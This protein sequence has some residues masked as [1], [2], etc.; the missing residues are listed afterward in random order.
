MATSIYSSAFWKS[1]TE[2]AIKTVGQSALAIVPAVF[3]ADSTG[4]IDFAGVPWAGIAGTAV[5]AGVVSLIT[6]VVFGANGTGPSAVNSE[7]KADAVVLDETELTA[8][9]SQKLL[10]RMIVDEERRPDDESE[11]GLDAEPEGPADDDP[12]PVGEPGP[13]LRPLN[14]DFEDE[15][16]AEPEGLADDEEEVDQTP[17]PEGYS[18]RH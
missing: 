11:D 18:P 2:R 8:A 15:S 13:E 17:P 9:D 14:V 7:I 16:D 3:I 4:V 6:S 10:D 12:R 5:F 1:S